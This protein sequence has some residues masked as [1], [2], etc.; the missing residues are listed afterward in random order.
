[1]AEGR[2]GETRRENIFIE[3]WRKKWLNKYFK[4]AKQKQKIKK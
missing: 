2:L 4:E 1:M 3:S